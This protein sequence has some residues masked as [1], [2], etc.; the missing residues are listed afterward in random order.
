[1]AQ[2][3][4]FESHDGVDNDGVRAEVYVQK[5]T[6]KIVRIAPHENGKVAQIEIK[7]EGLK[8]AQKAWMNTDSE[9]F[10]IATK[11]F[12]K[13]EM[14]DYRIESQRR[15]GLD[16][17]TPI[18]EFR[19]NADTAQEKTKSILAGLNGVLSKEAVTD[20]AEDPSAGGRISAIDQNRA[21]AANQ[22]QNG[23]QAQGNPNQ[24]NSGQG[25]QNQG[26]R[27]NQGGNRPYSPEG[28][29]WE[30]VNQDGTRNIGSFRVLSASSVELFV[31]RNLQGAGWDVD[32]SQFKFEVY[33]YSNALM[34]I[35]DKLQSFFTRKPIDRMHGSHT[36]LRGTVFDTVE[37]FHPFSLIK[38][39]AETKE[40][41][42]KKV[43]ATAMERFKL[44]LELDAPTQP[45]NLNA[46]LG[47]QPKEEPIQDV[48]RDEAPQDDAPI[49]PA[50]DEVAKSVRPERN[51]HPEADMGVYSE[52]ETTP[53]P[54]EENGNLDAL[55]AMSKNSFSLF[56]PMI[57]E[58]PYV[59]EVDK[60][61]VAELSELIEISGIEKTDLTPL[62]RY[63]F[64][65][66]FL[67]DIEPDALGDFSIFYGSAEED[68]PG[69]LKKVIDHI[70]SM[71]V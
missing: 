45:F 18:A 63:T 5:G 1:M 8:F 14:V 43:G 64:G 55:A 24:G 44:V 65:Q 36:R 34:S 41:W 15:P 37:H 13:G 30:T 40:E 4:A 61:I 68:T 31:R 47:I 33:G 48:P 12:D 27:G 71:G 21:N 20:P 28:K 39:E 29:G 53:S 11:A 9:V 7:T 42:Y 56:P 2:G 22:P 10:E 25:G 49:D 50:H 3:F 54:E 67:K 51:V 23:G 57:N 17:T 46:F 35:V 32:D 62:I 58:T 19:V 69:N 52:N 16:R 38:E 70:K 60:S 66:S 59:G 26:Q 6:A